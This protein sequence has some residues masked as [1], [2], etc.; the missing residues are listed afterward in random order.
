ML[1]ESHH[2]QQLQDETAGKLDQNVSGR[3]A[4]SSAGRW[5]SDPKHVQECIEELGMAGCEAPS[6]PNTRDTM[7]KVAEAEDS[8]SE[9]GVGHVS[10]ET[11]RKSVS[12][13]HIYLEH[14][15]IET[16]SARQ[17]TVAMSSGEPEFYA[18]NGMRFQNVGDQL[19]GRAAVG[20]SDV[21]KADQ[22]SSRTRRLPEER[23]RGMEWSETNMD[24]RHWWSQQSSG[25][26][27]S[28]SS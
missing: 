15:L 23:R 17:A 24:T 12:C 2:E 1:T 26:T 3:V 22:R 10:D 5:N 28:G 25:K 16:Q 7:K 8:L 9:S 6:T 19:L 13:Y 11:T 4:S 18:L 14:C 21:D 27:C 20:T